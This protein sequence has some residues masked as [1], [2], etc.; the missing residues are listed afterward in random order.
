[1][2]VTSSW[3]Q[4]LIYT[5][6]A[7]LILL[8]KCFWELC[9]ALSTF[10]FKTIRTQVTMRQCKCHYHKSTTTNITSTVNRN[11]IKSVHALLLIMLSSSIH[12]PFPHQSF[13]FLVLSFVGLSFTFKVTKNDDIHISFDLHKS[14]P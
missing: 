11:Y 8:C 7:F 13:Q 14:G 9:T 2:C 1:M 10:L 5:S 12:V 3:M 4:G 6:F